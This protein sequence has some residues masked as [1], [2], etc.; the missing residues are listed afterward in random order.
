MW[1]RSRF[2]GFTPILTT[3]GSK[4]ITLNVFL[5]FLIRW[6]NKFLN[7]WRAPVAHRRTD[8]GRKDKSFLLNYLLLFLEGKFIRFG[9]EIFFCPLPG[10]SLLSV[11]LWCCCW[12]DASFCGGCQISG[13][14]FDL[15]TW[16]DCRLVAVACSTVWWSGRNCYY[17]TIAI[18]S[19][20][21][22][23]L[24]ALAAAPL[25]PESVTI[26]LLISSTTSCCAWD[27]HWN[28][29]AQRHFLLRSDCNYL[30]LIRFFFFFLSSRSNSCAPL[31]A[32]SAYFTTSEPRAK[33][34]TRYHSNHILNSLDGSESGGG[35]QYG[36]SGEPVDSELLIKKK[37]KTTTNWFVIFCFKRR[38]G[39][40]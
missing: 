38:T 28:W 2:A 27:G 39:R 24:P 23:R 11:A 16:I 3:L 31:P 6:I 17:R 33:L 29:I 36:R 21:S 1:R 25:L 8:G 19:S 40:L 22:R 20:R 10:L 12:F 5:K 9:V 15:S 32:T 13:S 7:G 34:L 30:K 37:V 26:S 14:L 18:Q 4:D 35:M